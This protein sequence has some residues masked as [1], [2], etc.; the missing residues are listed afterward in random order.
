MSEQRVIEIPPFELTHR[1]ARALEHA[2]LSNEDMAEHLGCAETTIRNYLSGRTHPRRPTIRDWAL[3]C[4]VPFE[5]LN[6]GTGMAPT[7]EKVPSSC[8]DRSAVHSPGR[9]RTRQAA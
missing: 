6:D 8:K 7:Q 1:L 2:H 5:W 3:R 9:A 4:G